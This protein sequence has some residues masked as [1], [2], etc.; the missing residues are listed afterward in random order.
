DWVAA[1]GP[2]RPRNCEDAHIYRSE[3]PISKASRAPEVD[4]DHFLMSRKRPAAPWQRARR[5]SRRP[6]AT[7]NGPKASGA[8]G[9]HGAPRAMVCGGL[10]PRR[11]IAGTAQDVGQLAHGARIPLFD[12]VDGELGEVIAQVVLRVDGIP[13]PAAV[14][15]GDALLEHAPEIAADPGGHLRR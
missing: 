8:T 9:Q 15:V 2:R 3:I 7:R 1:P 13:L 11:I 10:V 14:G 5:A 12:S 4:R 6:K